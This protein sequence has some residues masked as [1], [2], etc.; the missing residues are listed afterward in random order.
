MNFRDWLENI[1]DDVRNKLC[2]LHLIQSGEFAVDDNFDL[3]QKFWLDEAGSYC[4]D[5]PYF[6][7]C[8]LF[9]G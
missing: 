3:A 2:M 5:C 9:Y 4:P 7:D 1:D 6:T 8:I